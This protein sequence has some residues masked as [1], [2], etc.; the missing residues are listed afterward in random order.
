MALTID[1]A[2]RAMTQMENA[3]KTGIREQTEALIRS[4]AEKHSF[5]A[6]SEIA[7]L[8]E[9]T[10][11]RKQQ[12]K[13]LKVK[14]APKEQKPKRE[15]PKMPLPWTGESKDEWCQ[16]IRLNGGLHSQCT[17]EKA[18]DGSYC[19]TC[20]KGAD[21][22]GTGKPTYG[23][24]ED[25]KC[26]PILEFRDAKGKQTVPMANLLEKSK[27]SREEIEAEATKFGFTIPAEHW[28]KRVAK[29][30]RPSKK[31][32]GE[33]SS[34]EEQKPKRKPG[35]PKKKVTVTEGAPSDDL[36]ANLIAAASDDS[37]AS[38][39]SASTESKTDKRSEKARAKR[40]VKFTAEAEAAGLEGDAISSYVTKKESEHTAK[41]LAAKAKKAQ[42]KAEPKT[43]ETS[44]AEP[45]ETDTAESVETETA[46]PA[47][48]ITISSNGD[49]KQTAD[50]EVEKED[51][52]ESQSEEGDGTEVSEWEAPNGITYLK[53]SDGVLYDTEDHSVL[54]RWN[55]QTN[56]IEEIE[57]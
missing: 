36:I 2:Q 50:V 20:Q 3:L 57:E 41:L 16:G 45:V 56:E 46:V 28:D 43:V 51:V 14:A 10:V 15:V 12:K 37:A 25:R 47:I 33:S 22:N 30:G 42:K 31:S 26:Q 48:D 40:V 44:V 7:L 55:D 27:H 18:Q 4:L 32:D 53:S 19:T 52:E 11:A 17:N 9:T 35:R 13:K 29:R 5:D 38:D 1:I 23:D 8:T 49:V 34:D 6:D 24:V 54:G 21:K 39:S